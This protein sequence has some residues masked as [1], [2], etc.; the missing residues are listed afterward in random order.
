MSVCL[1]VCVYVNQ[2]DSQ[3]FHC[4][5]Y[6]RVDVQQLLVYTTGVSILDIALHLHSTSFLCP[7]VGAGH[8]ELL[9]S[10]DL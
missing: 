6:S 9:L 5:S 7:S 2:H 8:S 10:L 4:S 1:H 3:H